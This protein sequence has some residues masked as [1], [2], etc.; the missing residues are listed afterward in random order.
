MQ[1]SLPTDLSQRIISLDVIRGIAVLGILMMNIQSFSMP[2]TAYINPT[3]F[4]DLSGINGWVWGFSHLFIDSK[5]MSIFSLLFGVGVML[6]S[7]RAEDKHIPAAKLHKRRMGWLLLFG[8]IHGHLIWSGDVLFS[9]AV[10]GFWAVLFRQQS[11]RT[12]WTVGLVLI[13]IPTVFDLL[14]QSALSTMPTDELQYYLPDWQP[15]NEQISADIAT[16][17]GHWLGQLQQQSQD[18]LLMETY[19]FVYYVLW[20]VGGLMLI[21]MALYKQGIFSAAIPAQTL[22]RLG[23]FSVLTGIVVVGY[24]LYFNFHHQWNIR[25]SQYAGVQFNY[26][27]SVLMAIGYVLL[28]NAMIQKKLFVKATQLLAKTGRMAFTNYIMQSLL[29]TFL[30]YGF[31]LGWYGQVERWQ[32]LII[33]LIIWAVQL[34]VSQWWLA[35]YSFGPLEWLWRRLTYWR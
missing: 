26:I 19:G 7:E 20:R 23:S 27:G 32:Q 10:C 3:A 9:Y 14:S 6:F 30:F 16:F 18:A 4:G 13:S 15:N 11:V 31:G 25:Y 34:A 22:L 35:R 5:F 1:A 12:L 17:G 29:C 24:G 28:F 33:V 21:G 2:D 8:L